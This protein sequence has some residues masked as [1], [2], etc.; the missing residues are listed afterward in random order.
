MPTNNSPIL[1]NNSTTLEH[2]AALACAAA[3]DLP[4]P[5]RDLWNP[6]TC[7]A[8]LLP[9]LAWARSVD[10]WD[11]HWPVAT[12][13]KVIKAAWFIHKRKGTI[14]ALRR[15]VEPLGYLIE[16]REWFEQT[17]PGRRGTFRL[18]VGVLETGITA[19]MYP[20]LERIIADTKPLSRHLAGLEI[21]LESRG[22]IHV[23]A[24]LFLGE[25]LTVYPWTPAAIEISVRCAPAGADHTIDTLTIHPISEAS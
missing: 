8:A 5:I 14:S 23:G 18:R 4:L 6:D 17:P 20:E 3:E 19:A 12:K 15:A 13:R 2:R 21:S 25:E 11:A 1:P 16:I 10:R 9:Y 7:P 24:T 22:R